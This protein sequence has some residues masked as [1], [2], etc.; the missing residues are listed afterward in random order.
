MNELSAEVGDVRKGRTAVTLVTPSLHELIAYK[1]ID[2][3]GNAR[4][5]DHEALADLA[6][7]EFTVPREG[8]EC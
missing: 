1:P 6:H 7:G 4:R 3:A 8:E 5:V 2:D